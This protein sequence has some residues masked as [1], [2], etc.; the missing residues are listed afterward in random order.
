[1]VSRLSDQVFQAQDHVSPTKMVFKFKY[2][3]TRT[4]NK[5]F[6]RVH[7]CTHFKW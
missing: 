3:L 4:T 2:I 5:L 1:M 6:R 7:N